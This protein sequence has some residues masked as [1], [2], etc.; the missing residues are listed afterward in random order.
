MDSDSRPN[1]AF[2]EIRTELRG[3]TVLVDAKGIIKFIDEDE[4][5]PYI[6]TKCTDF[7][8]QQKQRGTFRETVLI[9]K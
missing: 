8:V 9:H 2:L 3:Y 5:L 7:I 1:E 4:L 6:G